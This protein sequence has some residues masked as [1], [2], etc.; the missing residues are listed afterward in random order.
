MSV[1]RRLL[2]VLAMAALFAAMLGPQSASADCET[3]APGTF[4]FCVVDGQASRD[5]ATDPLAS[6]RAFTQA[7]GHPDSYSTEIRF[8]TTND[9]VEGAQWPA[10]PAKTIIAQAP[11]GLLGNPT[12]ADQCTLTQLTGR[13]CP[14]SSQVG[15][16]TVDAQFFGS[17]IPFLPKTPLYSMV[18]P[19]GLP[20]RFSFELFSVIVTVDTELRSHGDYGL[21][22][23]SRYTS[24]GLPLDGVDFTFWGT[25][26]DPSHDPDR[27]CGTSETG[28]PAGLSPQAFIRM[29]TICSGPLRF[30]FLADTWSDIGN[31]ATASFE[32]HDPP[33]LVPD[34][35]FLTN[36]FPGLPP[37]GFGPPVGNTGCEKVPVHAEIE[38]Q[39]TALETETPSGLEVSVEVPNPGIDS[40]GGIASSDIKAAEVTLPQGVTLNPSQA[41]GLGVCTPTQ[42][43]STELSFHPDGNHGCP[44]D[45]KIGT[46]Q[47]KTPLLEETLPGNVY[48]ARQDDPSTPQPGAENPFDSL[49]ALYVVIESPERGILV[50]LP[51]K[52][53]PNEKT[54]RIITTFEDLPQLPFE[55]F[56][57][58]FREGA[59]APLVTP[60]TCGTY[61]TEA[62]FTPWSDPS[63]KL[64][65]KSSF[66]ITKGIG[67][68][69]CP[70]AG[71]PPFKPGFSAGSINNNAGSFSPFTMRLTRQDGEQDMT[72][73]S[74]VLP[75]GVLGKLAGVTKCPDSA[76]ALAKSK[77][78]RQELASP[79]CP[80]N[81][82]I[83]R[84]LAGAGVGS[85]LTYVP[86]KI[87]L[88][89]PVGGDPLSVIVITPAVAGPF[90]V[91]TVVVREALTLNPDTAEVEVDGSASDPI[92]HI[93]AGIPLK[94]RDLR[95]YVDRDRFILNPTS[96]DPSSVKAT[97]FGSY[98]DVF[99]PADDVPV[100]LSDR[101]QA[102]NCATLGFKPKLSLKLKGGTRRG[103][104]PALRAVLHVRPGDANIGAATVTLPRS[105]FL[106]QAHIR[107]ICTRVQFAAKAC[108]KGSI[109]GYARAFTPLLDEP[110]EGPVYLRS[111]NHKLPDLVA[112]LHGLVDV[113]VVGRIDSFKG[114]IRS[115]F[116]SVPDAPVSKFVLS[117]QGAKKGL[118]INSRDLCASKNRANAQF[119]GQNG[120]PY[121]FRP[122]LKPRCT[123]H[124]SKRFR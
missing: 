77:T 64:V 85:V 41:E 34:D 84:I 62:V 19:P 33:G 92:P 13:D 30:N 76:I 109:Y 54:G 21:D 82:E 10:A 120:K 26:A 35:F 115:S 69:P 3:P 93:L 7:G 113:N 53:E 20:A 52:V 68:G 90:D 57:F 102:A 65:A 66:Q 36:P 91:G 2:P 48:I 118:V 60:P 14:G 71:I 114:G 101:Y 117:M 29:P 79:S 4:G 22:F 80:A 25:P 107:T 12:V 8:N 116:E 45:S 46:V 100:A 6:T 70:Q 16:V 56:G 111:S 75:P 42:Y 97:L 67:G 23:V 89:G 11:P 38:T 74:S 123:G 43:E 55:S 110:I 119:T 73:F 98:L 59:R 81:S 47:V 103:G 49:L 9:P 31:F 99:N 39:P 94:L 17:V 121:G 104:H 124:K 87:Y 108:P 37:G 63:R 1:L 15:V 83:G 122:E 86:G 58:R 27:H 105:A 88:G 72:R 28:C 112:A 50:K 18:A 61:E 44:S 51:A 95:V 78:G 32:S 96:C 40:P 5:P 106:D 24:T